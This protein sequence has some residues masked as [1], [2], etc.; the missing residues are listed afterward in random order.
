MNQYVDTDYLASRLP[1]NPRQIQKMAASGELPG[2]VRLRENGK[3]MFD[4]I[5]VE[6][7]L[8]EKEAEACRQ[9]NRTY[10]S[11]ANTGGSRLSARASESMSRLEK[12]LYQRQ[13]R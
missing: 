10:T 7:F 1:Y 3:W 8:K 2:A 4:L 9:E 13:G 5:R 6:R 12:R 11:A